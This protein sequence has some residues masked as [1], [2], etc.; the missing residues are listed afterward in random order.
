MRTPLAVKR[1]APG[2]PAG[3]YPGGPDGVRFSMHPELRAGL[4]AEYLFRGGAED[5]SGHGRHGLVQGATLT[6]DR[7]GTADHAYRFDGR[8]D[9]IVVSPPPPLSPDAMSV[10]VC[11]CYDRRRLAGW[12]NCIVAQD[13][14]VDEDQARRDAAHA[15]PDEHDAEVAA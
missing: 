6:P 15:S 1:S 13:D 9:A 12:S 8:D 11:A 10:S 4:V 5:T 14:G 3:I 2:A 7:F